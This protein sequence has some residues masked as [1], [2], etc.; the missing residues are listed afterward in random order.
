M[1]SIA[2]LLPF[3]G[4]VAF[5][6]V[7]LAAP[8]QP[9]ARPVAPKPVAPKA[10]LKTIE[11]NRD[12][13]QILGKCFTCHGADPKTRIAGL[14]L[15]T[16]AGAT[17]KLASGAQAIVPG[18]PNQSALIARIESKVDA[19]RMPPAFT[20]KTI[21]ADE[22]R[23]LRQWIAEG[24]EY[25]EHWAFVAPV[26]WPLPAVKQSAWARNP[27]DRFVLAKQEAAGL[28]PSPEADKNTLIRRVTLDLTGLP[29]TPK[30]VDAFLADRSANAYEK[31]VDRL[32]A[33]PR[34]GE[35]MAM[36]WMDYARYADSNGYQADFERFQWRWR[37]WVINAFN[38][39]MP[40]D[41]FT[42]EQL[43]GDMLPNAT[44]EQKIATG[45]NRNHRINT[46]G[47][48]I[49]E[50]WRVETVIDRVETTS[51][52]WLGL[53]TGCARCHDHKYDPFSQKEFYSMYAYFNNVPE[54]G[55][56]EERPVNHPPFIQ[57]PTASQRNLLAQL[58]QKSQSLEKSLD[59]LSVANLPKAE[60]WA[61][62]KASP[63]SA[64]E[65]IEVRYALGTSPV[66]LAGN[67]PVPVAKNG[68]Q[69]EAGRSSGA[70]RTTNDAYV[71][72]GDAGDFAGDKPYS[73]ALWVKPAMDSGSPVARMDDSK[74]Y[75]GWDLYLQGGRPAAHMISQ[76]PERA[77]K[78]I[79]RMVI[80]MNDWTHLAVTSDGS[81]KPEGMRL[82]VNGT[83]IDFDVEVNTLSGDTR[84]SV[85]LKLGRR[86]NGSGYNGL[87]D[88]LVL[89]KRT[90]NPSEVKVLASVKL[91]EPLFAVAPAKRTLEQKKAIVRLWSAENDPNFQKAQLELEAAAKLKAKTQSEISS[92]MVMEEMPK[93]RPAYV[94]Q[95]GQ[96]DKLGA[97]VTMG[98]PKV[99]P[100]L[101]K[102]VANNRL[103]FA[104]WVV[105][106]TNPLTARVTVNRLWDRL[107]GTGIV[108]SVEDFGTRAEFPSHPELLDWLAVD[109]VEKGWDLKQLMKLMVTSATY[110]QSSEITATNLKKDPRNRLL[111]H[112][113]RFR[114]TAEVI[115][116]QALLAAGLLKN[117][118]GGPSVRPY[119]PA[120]IWD[121]TNVYGNLRNYKSD[122]DGNQYRRS[123]YTIW[124]RTAAPPGMTLFDAATRETC[125]VRRSRTNTPLQA[126]VLLNDETFVEASRVLAE[127]VIKEGG[128]NADARIA[129]AFRLVLGRAPTAAEAKVLR[130][131]L[132]KRIAA[133][134]QAPE[135]AASL[136]RIG[137]SKPD[138]TLST[139]EL[140]AYTLTASMILNLDEAITKE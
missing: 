51:A 124:K 63:D 18:K 79:G 74:A 53:T 46:E 27:I 8:S 14:R 90:L 99:L 29:P 91:G 44:T 38:R 120:G 140:A 87:V 33:S 6:A 102:G 55:T 71:D 13:R 34:Y 19:L 22:R 84:N 119:Q 121:E 133:F 70:A 62:A 54:S 86:T 12:V 77:L 111:A 115:R 93:P 24:A 106:P 92:V 60:E 66:L 48:V 122:A 114:L 2:K 67:A 75:R 88:D 7:A 130:A 96:Y 47:G 31:L 11:F 26:R 100:G 64:V 81:G 36:D 110:R 127:R 42:V 17:L 129:R 82:Y 113:P 101:P 112:A 72:L 128:P 30:E 80:P 117:Q 65:N 59:Q 108:E 58:T 5:I 16:R 10:A 32:L 73:Y 45:F 83:P 103:G 50:E 131:G 20:H 105:S 89:A 43:A 39:N 136:I 138:P 28:K 109:F 104:K 132:E 107:F 1:N 116:D 49:A 76:W 52:V 94:L 40:Y 123:L 23:I 97:R 3:L 68:V 135:R 9:K 61:N 57:A 126:L 125:R 15:D 78:I 118:V 85:S 56:G 95:R 139:P 35:R 137:D 69:F 98:L 41:Q 4:G 25:K 37:D 21:S 134:Q